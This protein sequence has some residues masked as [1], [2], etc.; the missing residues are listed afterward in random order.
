MSESNRKR[1]RDLEDKK[2][3]WQRPGETA[4]EDKVP[5]HEKALYGL[6]SPSLG[7]V[8][9]I[10]QYQVQ[11]VLVYG[12]GMSPVWKGIIIMIYRIWDSLTDPIMGWI[13]DNTRTRFGRRRPYMFLGC[14]LMALLMP[15]VWRFNENWDMIWIAVWFTSFGILV[16]TATTIYNIPYQ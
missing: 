13:S 15:F 9:Q 7:L 2:K 8:D 10:I 16:S 12:M 6:G 5:I 11:Q 4:E 3:I 1:Q 14:L